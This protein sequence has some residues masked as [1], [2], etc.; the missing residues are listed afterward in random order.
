VLIELVCSGNKRDRGCA[1]KIAMLLT[2]NWLVPVNIRAAMTMR[3]GGVSGAPFDSLNLGYSTA[4]DRSAVMQN[5]RL[6]ATAFDVDASCIRW[7]HQIHGNIVHHAEALPL[8]EPLGST[9]IQGDA[10][11]SRTKGILCGVKIADCMPVLFAADDASVV[12]AAHAGWR[13]LASGVLEN[14][15]AAMD[16]ASSRI[17]AWLGPCIGAT[18]FEVGEEVRAAFVSASSAASRA[19]IESAFKPSSNNGKYLC[20]LVAIAHERLRVAGVT[21]VAV[22]GACTFMERERFFSHRRERTTGRMAAFVGI[23]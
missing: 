6:V 7:L 5:E 3:F 21:R 14:T 18:S 1:H 19:S 16:I 13:G 4:D 22:D 9:A 23:M 10:M 15:I 8:N 17:V 11:V 20:D 2:P 12:A